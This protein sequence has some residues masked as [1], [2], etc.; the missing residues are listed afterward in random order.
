MIYIGY[1]KID[2][3][4]KPDSSPTTSDN[5]PFANINDLRFDRITPL[6]V[7]TLEHNQ[8][9]LDGSQDHM[10]DNPE[11]Y[12]WGLWSKQISDDQG[13]F[14]DPPTLDITFTANHKS[15][16]VSL[17]FYPHA[18]D[19]A[20]RVR[21][22]WY[23]RTGDVVQSGTYEIDGVNG[24]IAENVQSFRRLRLEFLST[25]IRNRYGKLIGLD[26]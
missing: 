10:A 2:P 6:N 14:A 19:Y 22:T 12:R 11:A 18:D 20:N 25:N 3:S 5:Q 1:G 4:A 24:E 17:Y 8:G 21:A 26:Y 13:I 7:N 15:P 23:D 9:V 16:G